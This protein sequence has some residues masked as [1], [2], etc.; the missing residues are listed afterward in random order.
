MD[1]LD[2]TNR[3]PCNSPCIPPLLP[4]LYNTSSSPET[5]PQANLEPEICPHFLRIIIYI[6]PPARVHVSFALLNP[7]SETASAAEAL[8]VP[9]MAGALGSAAS[10]DLQS[11]GAGV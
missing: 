2:N 6:G 9:V 4:F 10:L 11:A 7:K 3:M 5:L 1:L 8:T